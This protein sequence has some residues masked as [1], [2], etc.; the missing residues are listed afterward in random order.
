[1]AIDSLALDEDQRAL[2]A[3]LRAFLAEQL[4]SAALRSSLDGVTGYDPALHTRLAT[5]L[6]LTG[7]TIPEKFGGLGLSQACPRQLPPRGTAPACNRQSGEG[8]E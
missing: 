4:S 7:L 6:G 1:M 2:Q 8:R 3:N 5:E